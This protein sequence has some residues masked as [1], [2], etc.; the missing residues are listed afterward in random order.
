MMTASLSYRVP[1]GDVDKMG[2]VYYANYFRYFEMLRNELIRLSSISYKE[3][4]N[5]YGL[6][7]PV[8]DAYCEYLYPA[9]YDDLI[10]VEGWVSSLEANRFKISYIIWNQDKRKLVTGYTNHICL[11]LE[12]RHRK[13]PEFIKKLFHT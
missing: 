7:F 9:K 8:L 4:E 12:G 1:Y 11:S 13:L 5:Q 10:V 3:I 6:M 2:Y